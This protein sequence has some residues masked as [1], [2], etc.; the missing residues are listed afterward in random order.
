MAESGGEKSQ[1]SSFHEGI[2]HI[3]TLKKKK[4]KRGKYG[5]SEHNL[6]EKTIKVNKEK[7]PNKNNSIIRKQVEQTKNK[8]TI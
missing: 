8:S 1:N 6:L 3:N 5:R 4:K 7:T 2:S